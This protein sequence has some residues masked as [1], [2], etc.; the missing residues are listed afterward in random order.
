MIFGYKYLVF[1]CIKSDLVLVKENI[2]ELSKSMTNFPENWLV[3]QGN[4]NFRDIYYPEPQKGGAHLMKFIIWEPSSNPGT[5]VF[6]INYEDGWNSIIELY[7]K[8]FNQLCVQI[9]LSD[10]ELKYPLYKFSYY[11]ADKQRVLLCYKD[12]DKWEFYQKGEALSFEITENYKK[13][14]IKDRLPNSLI[15]KYME[16]LGWN[17]NDEK[18]W[19]TNKPVYSFYRTKWDH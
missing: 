14:R 1:T 6:F 18:F 3:T 8:R 9:C 19:I 5:T 16:E 7:A 12:Y 10:I 2:S 11:N 4:L 15:Y 13:R 17:I